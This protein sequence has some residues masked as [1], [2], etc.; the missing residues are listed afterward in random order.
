MRAAW[1]EHERLTLR[2]VPAPVARGRWAVVEVLAVG[3]CGTDLALA[4]GLYGFSGVP[5]HEFVG[6]VV[7]G[8]A[9][10]R[11]RRVVADINVGCGRCRDCRDA[12]ARHCA[13]RRVLGIRGLPG[14]FAERVQVPAGNLRAVP[15]GLDVDATVFC[16]PLAA[17]LDAC[18]RVREAQRVLVVGPGRLGQLVVRGLIAG[19]HRVACVGRG[20]ASLARLP[21]GVEASAG[22]P[23]SWQR[24]FDAVVEASGHPGGLATALD[25][26]RPRGSL[27]LKSTYGQRAAPDLDRIVVDEIRV[28]GSRCGDMDEALTWLKAGRVDPRELISARHGL[29]DV[30]VAFR[31]A[32]M[33]GHCKVLVEP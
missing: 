31:D 4:A 6:R 24:R 12:N 27:I 28:I 25:A 15:R 13:R 7:A 33:P 29:D 3:V 14:A 30:A 17:A 16:E 1:L 5:G 18:H 19:G 20:Q 2:S 32:A 23:A 9:A 26:V 21:R 10:W 22:L 8:P 11:G